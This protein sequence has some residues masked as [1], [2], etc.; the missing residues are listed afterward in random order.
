MRIVYIGLLIFLPL[1]SGCAWRI[2]G[3]VTYASGPTSV[4]FSVSR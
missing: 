4:S 3:N 2:S 1:F